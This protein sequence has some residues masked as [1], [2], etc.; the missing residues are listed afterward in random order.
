MGGRA[1]EEVAS[2]GGALHAP[3]KCLYGGRHRTASVRRAA[4]SGRLRAGN[5]GICKRGV[6]RWGR[7]VVGQPD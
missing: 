4:R 6:P 2:R 1:R 5:V 7:G 3:G